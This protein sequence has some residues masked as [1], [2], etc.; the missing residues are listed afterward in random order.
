MA[1]PLAAKRVLSTVPA[2]SDGL[3]RRAAKPAVPPSTSRPDITHAGSA[4]C[5]ARSPCS[6]GGKANAAEMSPFARCSC[7]MLVPDA[8]YGPGRACSREATRGCVL[9]ARRRTL[10]CT[11][12]SWEVLPLPSS[13]PS[14][15]KDQRQRAV[16]PPDWLTAAAAVIIAPH[17]QPFGRGRLSV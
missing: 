10:A 2:M 17:T 7:S 16:R 8:A 3:E 5:G 6:C 9:I 11:S 14:A 12:S 13:S 1:Y 15:A 4:P